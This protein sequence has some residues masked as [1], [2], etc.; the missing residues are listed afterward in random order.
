M[1]EPSIFFLNQFSEAF[2]VNRGVLAKKY[3]NLLSASC[4]PRLYDAYYSIYGSSF[5]MLAK[6]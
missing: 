1:I 3:V 6:L 4:T 2:V 5:G